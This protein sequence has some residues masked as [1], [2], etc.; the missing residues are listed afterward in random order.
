VSVTTSGPV[1]GM[2][3]LLGTV[4]VAALAGCG[5]DSPESRSESESTTPRP[6]V[7]GAAEGERRFLR[8]GVAPLL[9]KVDPITTGSRRLVMATSD[10]PPGDTIGVHRHLREDELILVTRGM[11]RVQ[12]GKRE[13]TA[14]PGTTV[15]IPQG[16]CIALANAGRD[17]FSMAFVFSSPG[18]EQVLRE[19]SSPEGAPPKQYTK[20]TRAAAFERGHAEAGSTDC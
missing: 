19:L 4:T 9:I 12:L 16:T 2:S 20:E 7:I 3:S 6:A 13:Y 8:G 5:S 1:R 10:L 14:G 11:A 15:F 18:F 17:T